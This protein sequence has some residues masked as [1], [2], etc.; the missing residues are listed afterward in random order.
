[1]RLHPGVEAGAEPCGSGRWSG[2]GPGQ[3]GRERVWFDRQPQHIRGREG[4]RQ[5]DGLS[6]IGNQVE[7]ATIQLGEAMPQIEAGKVAPLLVFSEERNTFLPDT[8]TAKEHSPR[9]SSPT[10]W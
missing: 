5:L 1:M 3:L 2:H 8:P 9:P 6:G 7:L 4:A 10:C